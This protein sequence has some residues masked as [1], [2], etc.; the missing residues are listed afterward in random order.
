MDVGTHALASLTL[1]RALLPRAPLAVWMLTVAAGTLADLDALSAIFGPSAYLDWH[2]AF[3]HSLLASAATSLI[4]SVVYLLIRGK[5]TP[6]KISAAAL[7]RVVLLSGFLHLAMDACQS[8]GIA[9]FWPFRARRIAADWLAGVDPWIIAILL[10]ALLLPELARLVSDEIGAKSKVPRGRASAIL[11]LIV[12]IVYA[13]LRANF[14]ASALAAIQAR[15]YRG[16]SPRRSSAYP[17]SVSIF[18]WHAIVETDHALQELTV[19]ATPGAS[20]DP[21]NGT[22]LF[23]PEPSPVLDSAQN[24]G[25]ARKFLRIASFPKAS[26]EKTPEGYAVQIRDLR[27]AVSGQTRHEVIAVIQTDSNGKVRQ[28]E[29]EWG[30]DFRRR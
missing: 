4:L 18:T 16:E 15:T 25:A 19:D 1:T 7:L 22:T 2:R 23:K 29:F 8:A 12:I 3:M 11:G 28:D 6:A 27:Y 21:E 9:L 17:E 5:H 26:I 24:A 10:A 13:G 20:F 14:H 30:R